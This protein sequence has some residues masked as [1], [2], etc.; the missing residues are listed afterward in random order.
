MKGRIFTWIGRSSI[1]SIT[2]ENDCILYCLWERKISRGSINL[3]FCPFFPLFI[4][5]NNLT[6]HIISTFLHL[7][8]RWCWLYVQQE[9]HN[10]GLKISILSLFLQLWY[11]FRFGKFHMKIF[12]IK[13]YENGF[14]VLPWWCQVCDQIKSAN[15]S[16][17]TGKSQQKPIILVAICNFCSLQLFTVN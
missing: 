2:A 1:F 13:S 9:D 15:A 6:P 16:G 4:I 3:E 5:H 7:L 11:I 8:S 17:W 12:G 10:F 14:K